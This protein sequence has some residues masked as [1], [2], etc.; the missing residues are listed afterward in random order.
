MEVSQRQKLSHQPVSYLRPPPGCANGSP[1]RR[2]P[3]HPPPGSGTLFKNAE[4][5]LRVRRLDELDQGRLVDLVNASFGK[6]LRD[7]YLASLRPR[8]HSIYVSEG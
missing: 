1:A 4:R 6:K 2:A 3:S 8:L 7:D 5:M